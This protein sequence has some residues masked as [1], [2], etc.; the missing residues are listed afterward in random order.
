MLSGIGHGSSFPSL[1]NAIGR[2]A[3]DDSST[4]EMTGK[5]CCPATSGELRKIAISASPAG[6]FNARRHLVRSGP[7]PVRSSHA[8]PQTVC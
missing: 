5:D 2:P 7:P 3:M 8:S 1:S 6:L 4:V